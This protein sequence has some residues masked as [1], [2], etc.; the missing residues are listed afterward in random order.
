MQR[1]SDEEQHYLMCMPRWSSGVSGETIARRFDAL[2]EEYGFD[3]TIPLEDMREREGR[4]LGSLATAV[5]HLEVSLGRGRAATDA[6][7]LRE[8]RVCNGLP[9]STVA[10]EE[11][12]QRALDALRSALG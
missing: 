10:R 4:L 11:H 7:H 8:G 9:T 1:L 2:V 12:V 5:A 3:C 6:Y